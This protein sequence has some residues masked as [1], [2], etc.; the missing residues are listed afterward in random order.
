[1]NAIDLLTDA[2]LLAL[3]R[4]IESYVKSS[5]SA[6]W[7]QRFLACAERGA[8]GPYVSA[9]ENDHLLGLV[10]C[11]GVQIVCL[12]K[13]SHVFERVAHISGRNGTSYTAG[14]SR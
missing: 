7:R 13:C 14:A 10:E 1:M 9:D 12:L 6:K 4:F 5:R 3:G 2:Q 8:F 11:H